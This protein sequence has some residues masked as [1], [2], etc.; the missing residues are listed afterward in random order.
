M[1]EI[2]TLRGQLLDVRTF[3]KWALGRLLADNEVHRIVGEA[4]AGL[5]VARRTE[6]NQ[7]LFTGRWD[8]HPKYGRQF[9]VAGISVDVAAD[10]NALIPFLV[11]HYR[12]VGVVTADRV[13]Q[14]YADH[15]SLAE[16]RD[17]LIHQPELLGSQPVFAG[18]A[19]PV[20][21]VDDS[22]Q[23]LEQQVYRRLALQLGG[24][25]LADSLLRRLGSYLYGRVVDTAAAKRGVVEAAW[26]E[27]RRDCYIPMLHVDG[28]G[29]A[30]AEDIGAF[31]GVPKDAPER[32][33]A[34]AH[35]VLDDASKTK[36][37]AFLPRDEY[38]A[39]VAAL[40]PQA[41]F[42]NALA[43]AAARGLPVVEEDGR[44]YLKALLAAERHVAER[45]AA[46]ASAHFAPIYAGTDAL[47]DHAIDVAVQ[48]K[49]PDFRLDDSQHASLRA[50]L[51]S[52]CLLHTLTAGPGCGK[53]A[54]MEIVVMI[55]RHLSVCFVAPT[56]KAAKVLHSRV[57][58]YGRE[59]STIHRALEPVTDG[60]A[61]GA[62]NPLDYRIFVA[63]EASMIDLEL[64]SA[65]LAAIPPESHLILVGDTDQLPS[66]GPGR[67][68]EDA[69]AIPGDHNRLA[70]T[71][72][73]RGGILS[74][75]RAVREGKVADPRSNDV[76]FRGDMG[77]AAF[78]F[79]PLVV[80]AYLEAVQRAGL[81]NVSLILP[82]RKGR[83]DEPGW[84]VTYAN[85]QLQERLNPL[86][87]GAPGR[88]G[89]TMLDAPGLKVPDF[90]VMRIGDRVM[91]RKNLLIPLQDSQRP[92]AVGVDDDE[93]DATGGFEAVVNG[94]TGFLVAAHL[95]DA[96]G[97]LAVELD[98]DDG[99]TIRF[100]AAFMDF[101]ALAYATTVHSAQGSEARE[102]ILVLNNGHP[103]FLHRRIV[104][105]AVSRAKER[106]TIFGALW[107]LQKLVSRPGPD[108]YS[109]LIRR[110]AQRLPAGAAMPRA[111][112][113]PPLPAAEVTVQQKAFRA[114]Y[115]DDLKM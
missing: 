84:N 65:L 50:L 86:V 44:Y 3:G 110:V 33:A 105:T 70:H 90:P 67:L 100:P 95:N 97:L 53:T 63:D 83:R 27:L 96:G 71:H 16:L 45:F 36:G 5:A 60:F 93:S 62:D 2:A 77:E 74:L 54:L 88:R 41:N 46:M 114:D 72:R 19:R 78:G 48:D 7:Y 31:F 17:L 80:P 11:R 39:A 26:Q 75:V 28:Y 94:D 68:L 101:L 79:E 1:S 66:V 42:D 103:D 47:L 34:I 115:D 92:P 73:N 6:H 32:L 24:R 43:C 87:E 12:G 21:Y 22:G 102:V 18:R 23:S 85:A 49:G 69:V 98:L 108:R 109:G 38:R 14:W 61:R 20:I 4:L 58:P 111:Q 25:G 56:G 8:E 37:H 9:K 89:R 106:L 40:D 107:V 30:T 113:E 29:F 104:Y 82:R 99:R 10:R 52:R 51:T 57:A 13:V 55:V 76:D 112:P 35:H 91:V 15:A 59:A 81:A 64:A